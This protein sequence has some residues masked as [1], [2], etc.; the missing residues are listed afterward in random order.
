MPPSRSDGEDKLSD[1]NGPQADP[2]GSRSV[3]PASELTFLDL[4]SLLD[5]LNAS[6]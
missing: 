5:K 2:L 3:S 1:I 6:N 4:L